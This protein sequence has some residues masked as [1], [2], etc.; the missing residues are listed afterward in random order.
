V[1]EYHAYSDSQ[2]EDTT[3]SDL[4]RHRIDAK[5]DNQPWSKETN[6]GTNNN[7]TTIKQAS[8]VGRKRGRKEAM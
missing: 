6:E 4:L 7:Q 1:E 8:E 3:R 5:A 2:R